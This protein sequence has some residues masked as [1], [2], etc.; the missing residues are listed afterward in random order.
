MEENSLTIAI[1]REIR[2]NTART[3]ERVDHAYEGPLA[4][5]LRDHESRLR[6]LEG[7][8]EPMLATA[9]APVE[10]R[11]APSL[12]EPGAW[13]ISFRLMSASAGA[14]REKLDAIRAGLT[15]RQD[16]TRVRLERR[17]HEQ[18]RQGEVERRV[19]AT[20]RRTG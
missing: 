14:R 8:E 16:Q 3:N 4:G 13:V 1:L 11:R 5:T 12:E 10:A 7:R 15:E 19:E 17:V 20:E 6:R 2:D 9:L 18:P